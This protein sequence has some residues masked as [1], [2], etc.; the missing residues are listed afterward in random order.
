MHIHFPR[1][2]SQRTAL[3]PVSPSRP[4]LVSALTGRPVR[5]D[6]AMTG[7]ITL[8]GRVLPIGGLREKDHGGLSRR[9]AHRYHPE[10]NRK[11]LEEVV[12]AVREAPLRLSVPH[13]PRA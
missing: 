10:T 2:P 6:I 13:G 11:D 1:A 3:P 9:D 8:R 7:E 5:H 4:R 12:P